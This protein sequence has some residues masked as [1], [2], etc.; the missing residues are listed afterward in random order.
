M[1]SGAAVAL[2]LRHNR[3]NGNFLEG[4]LSGTNFRLPTPMVKVFE[5]LIT[6]AISSK[7]LQCPKTHERIVST[8]IEPAMAL[9]VV[10]RS[11]NL[12]RH[13]IL[14]EHGPAISMDL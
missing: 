3:S 11:S 9:R 12:A 7:S 13:S 2:L 6:Q 4:F 10:R 8:A 14:F 1:S 5:A